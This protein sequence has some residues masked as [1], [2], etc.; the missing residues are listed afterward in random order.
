MLVAKPLSV[1]DFFNSL[2]PFSGD[3]NLY[4]I[5]YHWAAGGQGSYHTGV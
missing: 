1:D 4:E 3:L 2:C 5:G